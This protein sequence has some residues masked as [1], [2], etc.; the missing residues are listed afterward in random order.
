MW[1]SNFPPFLNLWQKLLQKCLIAIFPLL[2]TSTTSVYTKTTLVKLMT[3][4]DKNRRLRKRN[5]VVNIKA[6][7]AEIGFGGLDC[8]GQAQNRYSWRALVNAVMNYRIP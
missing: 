3:K 7:I 6:D 5:W 2:T 1:Q 8:I 4:T